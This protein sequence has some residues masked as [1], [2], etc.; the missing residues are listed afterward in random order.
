MKRK[1]KIKTGSLS[2]FICAACVVSLLVMLFRNPFPAY[3]Q[4]ETGGTTRVTGTVVETPDEE[5]DGADNADGSTDGAD[6]ADGNTDGADGSDQATVGSVSDTTE[7]AGTGD[8]DSMIACFLSLNIAIAA[9]I[10]IW[11]V[12]RVREEKNVDSG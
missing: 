2:G 11:Y 3:A 6:N 8:R 10:I 7:R 12:R 1:N 9:G 4:E 5:P